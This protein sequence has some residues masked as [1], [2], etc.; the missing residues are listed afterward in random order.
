[1]I[2]KGTQFCRQA[3]L[4]GDRSEPYIRVHAAQTGN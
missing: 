3:L 2:V 4:S 1:M